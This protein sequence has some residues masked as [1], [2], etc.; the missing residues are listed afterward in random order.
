MAIKLVT[1]KHVGGFRSQQLAA[2]MTSCAACIIPF[3]SQMMAAAQEQVYSGYVTLA[4]FLPCTGQ[5]QIHKQKSYP[6]Q[7]CTQQHRTGCRLPLN[8]TLIKSDEPD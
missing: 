2:L 5:P 3:V 4:T 6:A 8:N 1:P 7:A